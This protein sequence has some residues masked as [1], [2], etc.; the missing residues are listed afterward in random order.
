MLS[1]LLKIWGKVAMSLLAVCIAAIILHNLYDIYYDN[2]KL[3]HFS[4][5]VS[6]HVSYI[7]VWALGMLCTWGTFL[8]LGYIWNY[9]KK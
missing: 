8:L 1:F 9:G 6:D 5:W 2:D 4:V 3:F 7:I